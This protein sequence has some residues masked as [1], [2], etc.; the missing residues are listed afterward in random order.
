MKI[1]RRGFLKFAGKAT[2]AAATAGAAVKAGTAETIPGTVEEFAGPVH[3]ADF[4]PMVIHH[5]AESHVVTNNVIRT[6]E[7]AMIA[8]QKSSRGDFPFPGGREPEFVT[9]EFDIDIYFDPADRSTMGIYAGDPIKLIVDHKEAPHAH[10]EYNVVI[11]DI[12][13]TQS[14]GT[15]ASISLQM[16]EIN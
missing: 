12:A 9:T 3:G 14:S 2:V 13:I 16:R 1:S 7:L 5:K 15:D 4:E 6:S 10:G 11:T 8:F